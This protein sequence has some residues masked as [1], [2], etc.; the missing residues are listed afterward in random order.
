MGK[1]IG[2][3]KSLLMVMMNQHVWVVKVSFFSNIFFG[4]NQILSQYMVSQGMIL[5]IGVINLTLE[6]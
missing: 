4:L 3:V 1:R 6:T 5:R 2:E